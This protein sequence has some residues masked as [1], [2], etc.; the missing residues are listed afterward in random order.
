PNALPAPLR[1]RFAP[2]RS[3]SSAGLAAGSGSGSWCLEAF[4]N[5][6][7]RSIMDQGG[8]VAGVQT[9]VCVPSAS[10][11]RTCVHTPA[12]PPSL[13]LTRPSPLQV[14]GPDPTESICLAKHEGRQL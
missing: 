13:I 9:A 12:T 1:Q 8:R 6:A 5:G 3:T 2:R 11:M 4:A 10:D 14:R 7:E